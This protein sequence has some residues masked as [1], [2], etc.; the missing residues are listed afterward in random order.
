MI[1]KSQSSSATGEL[2]RVLIYSAPDGLGS[3]FFE[4]LKPTD[5]GG[6]KKS[7][8]LKKLENYYEALL[9]FNVWIDVFVHRLPT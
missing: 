7:E 5:V 3:N 6:G 4:G 1:V 2:H 9:K 8:G